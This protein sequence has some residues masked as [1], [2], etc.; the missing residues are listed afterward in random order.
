MNNFA[1]FAREPSLSSETRDPTKEWTGLTE[2]K[3]E[4]DDNPILTD[5]ERKHLLRQLDFK[6]FAFLW[7]CF[8]WLNLDRFV[9]QITNSCYLFHSMDPIGTMFIDSI[10]GLT[11]TQV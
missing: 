3:Q 11:R 8:L 10:K 2:I 6:V 9:F 5:Q 1:S 4:N 7:W